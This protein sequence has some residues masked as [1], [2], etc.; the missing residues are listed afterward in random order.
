MIRALQIL[1]KYIEEG[2]AREIKIDGLSA[3]NLHELER[4][5]DLVLVS[6][7]G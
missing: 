4:L 7:G 1:E 6:C 5:P 3:R 2:T